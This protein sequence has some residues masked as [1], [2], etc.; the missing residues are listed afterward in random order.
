MSLTRGRQA[1]LPL[2]TVAFF[3]ALSLST[4]WTAMPFIIQRLGGTEEHVGL[5]LALHMI[6]YLI[7]L[8]LAY[9]VHHQRYKRAICRALG[10]MSG[11]TIVICLAAGRTLPEATASHPGRIW[12]IIA[13]GTIAGGA[14]AF[15]WPNLMGW[16]AR[17]FA[18][19]DLNRRLGYYNVSWSSAVVVGPI[20]G[21]RLVET[22]LL[23]PV[24]IPCALLMLCLVVLLPLKEQASGAHP[25]AARSGR[26]TG[27]LTP[28]K[29]VGLCWIS[30]VALF[31]T[32]FG[33]AILRSQFALLWTDLG[34]AKS[35]FGSF[36]AVCAAS[37]LLVFWLAGR[38]A[39]W[40]GRSLP[41]LLTQVLAALSMIVFIQGRCAAVFFAGAILNGSSQ[42]FAYSAHLY[43]SAAGKST[44]SRAMVVHE[45][46]IAIA[47]VIGSAL[48]GYLSRFGGAYW[49][50]WLCLGLACASM[51]VQV[52]I[53]Y[54]QL[55]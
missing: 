14:L 13:A 54:R 42:G 22:S 36:T 34:L 5:A 35:Q 41:V 16:A 6:G 2:Y 49:P 30:R 29:Y 43:Y 20:L 48:G 8:L 52:G 18:A 3:M 32:W 23:T 39:A 46:T 45:L 1:G 26:P 33:A 38:W 24:L 15:F 25:S 19:R 50:Y 28:V 9:H 7:F 11:A 40:H 12:I 51:L 27:D 17:G 55:Y 47:T 44:R 4:W 53:H 37:N 31:S 21:A 10:A